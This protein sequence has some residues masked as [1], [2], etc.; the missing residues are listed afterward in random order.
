[1]YLI[2][3]KNRLRN[4]QNCSKEKNSLKQ[5]RS[6][7]ANVLAVFA[8]YAYAPS[9]T[10]ESGL[11]RDASKLRKAP[12]ARS[13]FPASLQRKPPPEK[14]LLRFGVCVYLTRAQSHLPC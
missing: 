2:V 6:L 1:V 4:F 5:M 3:E 12:E 7:R 14:M 11:M 8:Q 9:R 13:Y 10:N